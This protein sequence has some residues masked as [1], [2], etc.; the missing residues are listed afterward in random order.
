MSTRPVFS[1]SE[2]AYAELK[3]AIVCGELAAGSKLDLEVLASR[4][5][6]SRMPIREALGRL[7]S[8]GLVSIHPQRAT[9]VAELS[10][11]DMVETYD[12]RSALE[13]LL[14]ERAAVN[15]TPEDIA[16][17]EAEIERQAELVDAADLEGFL[18]SD[19]AFHF[20]LFEIA[21]A[22]R[23][24]EILEGLRN[25]AERYIY[26][27]LSDPALRADS[28]AAHREIVSLCA[29]HDPDALAAA[30]RAHVNGGKRRLVELLPAAFEMA[31][32]ISIPT[33]AT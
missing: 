1:K 27:Y 8:Q 24:I 32:D 4:L 28:V 23:T 2:Y 15:A 16:A 13:G 18:A 7:H 22:P 11:S 26:L 9:H 14:A 10:W 5:G 6:I 3:R 20:R 29:A 30:V 31:P 33:G 25:V 19:R 21:R 12:A 17:L